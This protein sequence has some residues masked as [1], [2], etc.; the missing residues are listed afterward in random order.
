MS[1]IRKTI[2]DLERRCNLP[3]EFENIQT[4]LKR[5]TISSNVIKR[6]RLYLL[7]DDCIK[8]WP[9]REAATDINTYA[10]SHGF[11]HYSDTDD[12]K[13]LYYL[14]LYLNLLHFA[15]SY[16]ERFAR[17]FDLTWMDGSTIDL[18]CKR[19]IENIEF[20]LERLNM[21]VRKK[22]AKPTPQYVISKRDAQVD[23]VIEAVPDLSEALL[24]YLD[25]R[26]QNDMGVKEAVLKVIAD[27]LEDR[28]REN[29]YKGTMNSGLERDLFTVFNNVDVRHSG[30]KQ[31]KLRKPAQMKLYDQTFKAAIHLLQMED[32][33]S[34]INTVS[35]LKK[36]H[37]ESVEAKGN[38]MN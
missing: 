25:I 12:D 22:D 20:L 11:L 29:Y 2:F 36:K 37:A 30:K 38:N 13:M 26:N 15:P 14:E 34:F 10:D 24:S 33:K 3:A 19:C 1:N 32:V 27:Y 7:L 31:W 16:E 18:E 6:T 21:R 23:A 28:H 4:D 9:Y 5:T 8:L 35:D 17:T